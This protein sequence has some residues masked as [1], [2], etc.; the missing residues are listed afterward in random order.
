MEIS[1]RLSNIY[2]R[3]IYLWNVSNAFRKRAHGSNQHVSV[4]GTR[5]VSIRA[6]LN[7]KIHH[8]W[9]TSFNYMIARFVFTLLVCTFASK[10]V[11]WSSNYMIFFKLNLDHGFEL[12]RVRRE[13]NADRCPS[14]KC[15]VRRECNADRCPS[16]KCR[17]RRECNADRCPSSKCRVRRECNADRCPSS[18]CRVRRECNADRCPSRKCNEHAFRVSS[19]EVNRI[20]SSLMFSFF[21]YILNVQHRIEWVQLDRLN[22]H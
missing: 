14:S 5:S 10:L 2:R 19:F 16:S 13:C 18:K 9:Y 11:S 6:A 20:F 4:S 17:V 15:R 1:P 12:S 3:R 22:K 7:S 8:C 21:R